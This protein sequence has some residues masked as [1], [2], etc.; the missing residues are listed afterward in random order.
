MEK[1]HVHIKFYE[2][3]LGTSPADPEIYRRYIASKSED[4]AKIEEEV[5]SLGVD[6]VAER[7]MTVFPRLDDG[8]PSSGTNR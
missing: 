8:T 5:A 1:I 6:G 3:V 2:K 4:A 7:G